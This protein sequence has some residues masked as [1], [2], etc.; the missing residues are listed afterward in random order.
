MADVV[1]GAVCGIE[2][3]A[4]MNELSQ[5]GT[6]CGESIEALLNVGEFGIEELVDVA[7]R[8][9]AVIAEPDDAGDLGEGETSGLGVANEIE[10]V[11]VGVGVDTVAVRGACR[12]GEQTASFVEADG[13]RWMAR[14]DG[15]LSDTHELYDTP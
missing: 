15:E 9:G 2:R 8:C 1:D 14:R 4:S 7:A 5:F 6:Q 12:F 3:S 11:P 13:S 10:S